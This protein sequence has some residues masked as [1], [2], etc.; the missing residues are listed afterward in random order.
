MRRRDALVLGGV[1][2]IAIAIPPYLR[3]RAT[4]FA[5]EPLNGFDGF[6]R[7]DRGPL[8]NSLDIFAGLSDP[9][10]PHQQ[11]PHPICPVVFGTPGWNDDTLPIAV[12]GDVNCPNCLAFE[13]RLDRLQKGGAPIRM[14]HHQLPLLGPRSVWAARVILA[15][16]LQG[17]AGAV[18][19][20][21]L[22]RVLRPGRAATRAVAER[23]QLDG[24]RLWAD[25]NGA[26]VADQ[27]GK[28]LG[29]GAALGIPGTPSSLVGRTLVIGAMSEQDLTRLI[30]LERSE[31]FTGC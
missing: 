2:A 5:F 28:A 1:A 15:A 26:I 20:D 11:P 16:G 7:L 12:F 21:L 13:N 19:R 22:S 25:A 29:L 8:T 18:Y 9:P 10:E 24:E 23:H 30:D 6:R 17:D 4:S 27:L 3:R 31:P 14:V